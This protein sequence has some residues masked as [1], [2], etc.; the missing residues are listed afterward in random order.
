V[1][2]E[3]TKRFFDAVGLSNRFTVRHTRTGRFIYLWVDVQ[4]RQEKS[5]THRMTAAGNLALPDP[6][7]REMTGR[8]KQETTDDR[9]MGQ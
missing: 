5:E 8:Q 3:E 1:I 6:A 7:W 2:D 9:S 4:T